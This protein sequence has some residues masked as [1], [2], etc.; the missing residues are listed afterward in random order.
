MGGEEGEEEEEEELDD[1]GRDMPRLYQHE[2][3]LLKPVN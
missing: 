3:E 2:P 1:D